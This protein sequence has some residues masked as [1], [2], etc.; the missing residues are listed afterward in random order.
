MGMNI[1]YTILKIDEII[2]QFVENE[3][4]YIII[5]WYK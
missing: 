4:T 5:D 1:I 3:K 2:L